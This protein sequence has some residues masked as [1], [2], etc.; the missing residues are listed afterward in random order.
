MSESLLERLLQDAVAHRRQLTCRQR[1][2]V[3]IKRLGLEMT[4][5]VGFTEPSDE[6]RLVFDVFFDF[7]S[8]LT[9]PVRIERTGRWAVSDDVA[10]FASMSTKMVWG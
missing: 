10:L 2:E 8:T 5:K 3:A 9:S 4:E 1:Y 7:D 6:N